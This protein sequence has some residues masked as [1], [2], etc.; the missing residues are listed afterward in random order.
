[1][2][3]WRRCWMR[4]RGGGVGRRSVAAE[5]LINTSPHRPDQTL[6]GLMTGTLRS[7][8]WRT[9]RV[10]KLA[11]RAKAMLAIWVSRKIHSLSGT[12]PARRQFGGEGR[13]DVVE[14]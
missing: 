11:R 3:G 6:H 1:M 8:K 7:W 13:F 10:A 2:P 9:Y 5:S 14:R 12:L 4:L